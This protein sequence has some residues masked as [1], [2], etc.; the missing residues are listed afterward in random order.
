MCNGLEVVSIGA[1]NPKGIR[2]THRKWVKSGASDWEKTP[3]G[4][5]DG[6]WRPIVNGER[7]IKIYSRILG[8][9]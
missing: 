8:Q 3:G 2:F 4:G 7:T 5:H 1:V 6:V 9:G